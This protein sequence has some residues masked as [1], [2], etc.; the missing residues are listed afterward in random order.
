MNGGMWRIMWVA[1]DWGGGH[2][3]VHWPQSQWSGLVSHTPRPHLLLRL[4]VAPPFV[5]G[6]VGAPQRP[7]EEYKV[8]LGVGELPW[9][10]FHV[11]NQVER[12]AQAGHESWTLTLGHPLRP[13]TQQHTLHTRYG[14]EALRERGA[15]VGGCNV[16]TGAT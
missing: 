13:A 12:L 5:Y 9:K 1:W 11:P 4:L 6:I 2:Q 7:H 8:P 14:N 15:P 10:D 3:T 16:R